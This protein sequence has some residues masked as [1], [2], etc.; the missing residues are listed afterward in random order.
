[1]FSLTFRQ[2]PVLWFS[3]PLGR[4]RS[5]MIFPP[6]LLVFST[7][8]AILMPCSFLPSPAPDLYPILAMIF[9]ATEPLHYKDTCKNTGKSHNFKLSKNFMSLRYVLKLKYWINISLKDD[10]CKSCIFL[11]F[12]FLVYHSYHCILQELMRF[13]LSQKKLL[14]ITSFKVS[15]QPET[16]P[17][18]EIH[19]HG[20]KLF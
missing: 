8:S 13:K 7:I 6:R 2:I 14:R 4:S 12:V 19:S 9:D 15:K 20:T 10:T 11:S 1:M 18:P 3:S 5:C 16:K 17:L